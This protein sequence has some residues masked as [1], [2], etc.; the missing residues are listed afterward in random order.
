MSEITPMHFY[1]SSLRGL[2]DGHWFLKKIADEKSEAV[3]SI[4]LLYIFPGDTV[5]EVPH[6]RW[7]QIQL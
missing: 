3:C 7:L 6:L 2:Q 5:Q 4:L 1:Y